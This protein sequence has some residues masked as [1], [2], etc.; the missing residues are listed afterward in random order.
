MTQGNGASGASAVAERHL[1]DELVEQVFEAS[2][3][4]LPT[5]RVRDAVEM[6]IEI[7]EIDKPGAR[8]AIWELRGELETLRRMEAC[9]NMS[10]ER[11]TLAMGAA[12]Q[13]AEAE[14]ASPEPS[15]R[16]CTEEALRWLEGRW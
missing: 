5:S 12:L 6:A 16:R 8:A 15:L 1:D 14:L 3:G 11:A 2:A 13:L 9:L 10:P 7:A 4:A